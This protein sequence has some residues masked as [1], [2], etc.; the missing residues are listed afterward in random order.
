MNVTRTK[1]LLRIA[2][3]AVGFLISLLCGRSP[4]GALLMLLMVG[5]LVVL[6]TAEP[7][8]FVGIV[9]APVVALYGVKIFDRADPELDLHKPGAR[10]FLSVGI[11]ATWIAI[12][13]LSHFMRS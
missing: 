2:I 8:F 3:P 6:A 9:F 4:S 13:L 11:F 7:L 10:L 12:G 5:L 1:W